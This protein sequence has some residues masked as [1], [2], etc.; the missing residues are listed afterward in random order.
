MKAR[1][2][3]KLVAL[4]RVDVEARG[5]RTTA[6]DR[7]VDPAVWVQ[8]DPASHPQLWV[9]SCRGCDRTDDGTNRDQQ[10]G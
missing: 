9:G 6:S 7:H 5:L 1:L 10:N 2:T 8:V 3:D 4:D